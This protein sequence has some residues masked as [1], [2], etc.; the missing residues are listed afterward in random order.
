MNLDLNMSEPDTL[1]GG[2]T[3]PEAAWRAA[4]EIDLQA[5]I[6]LGRASASAM[7]AL[8]PLAHREM[9]EALNHEVS[10]LARWGD[11]IAEAAAEIV[12]QSIP[13]GR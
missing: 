11:P 2:Y 12:R 7:L 4:V 8:S 6:A 5:A 10:S 3:D 1:T 9:R 13:V